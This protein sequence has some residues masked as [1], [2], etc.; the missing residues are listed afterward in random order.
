MDQCSQRHDIPSVLFGHVLTDRPGH[1]LAPEIQ[2]PGSFSA[3]R[4]AA[5]NQVLLGPV[6]PH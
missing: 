5:R 3:H 2:I 4:P 6:H 1:V